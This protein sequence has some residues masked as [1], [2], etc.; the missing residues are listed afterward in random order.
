[1]PPRRRS[2]R[3]APLT[4]VALAALAIAVPAA[5][6]AA[7]VKQMTDL[8]TITYAMTCQA[9]TAV[10]VTC[11]RAANARLNRPFALQ[12]VV[13]PASGPVTN[14]VTRANYVGTIPATGTD[15]PTRAWA[16]D[17]L[18]LAC[19]D[20]KGVAAY[21]DSV[22]SLTK[23]GF[24][25]PMKIGICNF[26]GGFA[27]SAIFAGGT[28]TVGASVVPPA[29]PTPAPPTPRPT[30]RP[31]PMPTATSTT[32]PTAAPTAAPTA[33]PAPTAAPTAGTTASPS[34][35]ASLP[36]TVSPSLAPSED[37]ASAEPTEQPSEQPSPQGGSTAEPGGST[38]P[39]PAPTEAPAGAASP[40]ASLPT[41][42]GSVA[43][44]T[45]VNPDAGA[46]GGNLLLA[47]LLLLIIGFIGELFNNTVENNYDEISGWFRKGP[48]R[49][50]RRAFGRIRVNPPGRPGVLLFIALTA[51]ISSFVDPGFGLNLRSVALFL[52]FLVGLIVVLASFKLPPIL[53]RRRR[54]GELGQLRPLPW[55]LV[56]AAVFVLTSRLAHL[57]P[58]YLYGIV[59][60]AIY[61][62]D[63]SDR[64]EGRETF[65]GSVWTLVAAVVAWVALMWLRGLGLPADG[66]GVT[67]LSTAF[68]ATI[69]AGLEAAA[70]ALMPLRFLPGYVIYR[71]NRPAW[72]ILWAISL[73]AFL[74]ILIGPT[75]GYVSD[76]SP[77]AFTAALGVFAAFGALSIATWLY[78]R[79]R[80]RPEPVGAE[81]A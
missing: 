43:G 60:G 80:Q 12:V 70:F 36:P 10:D 58:G 33:S 29:S 18:S 28:W 56:I 54:T 8:A 21:V 66:F 64:D 39:P 62:T 67:L 11:N 65:F 31:T 73:F 48:F 13:Q 77:E 71:W 76:L 69:V 38:E 17:L 44:I 55:A 42:S 14:V 40:G 9:P 53:A 24:G 4:F 51:F 78:F 25:A 75:S 72:A 37:P 22:H 15:G 19:G 26:N 63:V 74:H 30:P 2:G 46:I 27:A 50:V 49:V 16:T 20:P 68:A 79:V 3:L 41:F 1:M 45:D 81:P 5:V 52:G 47:L 57:Q 34:A 59:L 61:V 23:N 7:S 32:K 35:S 6:L